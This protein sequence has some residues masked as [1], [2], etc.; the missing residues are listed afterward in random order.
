[1]LPSRRKVQNA[2]GASII[3]LLNI[4]EGERAT[5]G[6]IQSEKDGPRPPGVY[7]LFQPKAN[8]E[9]KQARRALVFYKRGICSPT[10][11]L[12]DCELRATLGLHFTFL[13]DLDVGSLQAG[14]MVASVANAPVSVH[15][16]WTGVI[17]V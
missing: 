9:L 1:M 6:G 12:I 13:T 2:G 14:P 4:P 3:G 15:P 11:A 17:G 7:L 5:M 8:S 16:T 10:V